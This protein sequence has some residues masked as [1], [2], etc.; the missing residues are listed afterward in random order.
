MFVLV[1]IWNVLVLPVLYPASV[2]LTVPFLLVKQ[3][4]ARNANSC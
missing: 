1:S 4:P 2:Y 3:F